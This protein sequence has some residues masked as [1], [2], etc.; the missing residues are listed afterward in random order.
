[1]KKNI[2]RI[3]I[4]GYGEIGH[5]IA[6]F[7][8]NPK[9]KDLQRDDGLENLDVLH[10]CLPW[11]DKFVDIVK[12]EIKNSN[13]KLIII[14]S[15]VA[16]GTT[17]KIGG[18]VVHSPVR[19]LHPHLYEGIKTFVKYI[20]TDNKKAGMAAQKHLK[21]LGI[22]TRVFSPAATTELGKLLDTTYY[23]LAIAWHGEMK[24]LC[25]DFGVKF[26]EAVTDFNET[27]NT[28]YAKLGKYNVIRP[29]LKAPNPYI[30]GHC[31][32]PNAKLLKKYMKSTAI[33]LILKYEQ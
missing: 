6:K 15:T 23:G 12:K 2:S 19:G 33:E 32:I 27:Y 29:V 4:L 26:G 5:A 18:T 9:I 22:K 25:D 13:A 8:K 21:S 30:G 3:G 1:M 31:I 14:H 20:G 7:Y 17:K 28:G 11:S 24:R 16:P 10:V